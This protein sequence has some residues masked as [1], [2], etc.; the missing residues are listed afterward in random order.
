MWRITL[1]GLFAHKLRYGLTALSVVLAVGFMA[2]TLVFTDTI[3]RTFDGLFTDVYHSTSAVIRAKQPFTPQGNFTNQ[4]DKIDASLV[5]TVRAVPGV[6]EVRVGVE[7]YAQLV[8]SNH[9]AIGNPAAGAPT[10]GEAWNDVTLMNPYRFLPGGRPPR[11]ASEVAIDKHSADVGH[12][13]VG[14]RVLV[15][16]KQAP[17]VYTVTGIFRWETADSPLGASITLFDAVT[18]ARVL[19]SPGKVDEIDVA[20]QSGVTQQQMVDRLRA[21]VADP[22]LEVITGK[23][24]TQEGQSAIHKALSF[25]NLFLLIFA[26]IALFVGSFQ[27]FNTFSI[28]VAQRMREL[29]LV[30]AVGAGRAQVTRSI[31]GESLV[32]GVVA[33]VAG[34][35]AGVG[36]AIGLR[37]ILNAVG[38]VIPAAG[39][40]VRPRTIIVCLIVG[41]LITV[42]AAQSPARRAGRV[43]PIAVLREVATSEETRRLRR[44]VSGGAVTAA[45]L[46]LLLI[47]LFGQGVNRVALVG[48]GA[49]IVFLGLAVLGPIVSRPLSGLIG[50]ALTWRGPSGELARSNA[51]RNPKRTSATSAALMVGVALVAL[52]SVL[53]ASLK[54]S[55]GAAVDSTVRADFIVSGGG[56]PGGEA[57]FS[58]TLVQRLSRLPQVA[59]ATGVRAGS[60][61]V[62]GSNIVALAVD[63]RHVDDLFDVG[64]T[65]GSIS[66][67][68]TNGI[69]VS[70]A[71]AD[72]K[73]LALGQPLQ[74]VFPTTGAK[75]FT[76]Q[77]IYTARDVVG[78][79]VLPLAAAEQNY[80]Q[81]LDFQ[82]YV[83]LAPGVAASAAAVAIDTVLADYPTAKLLDRTQYKQQQQAQINQV[84][85]LVY[86]LLGLALTIALVGIANT[87]ALSIHERT[88]E[89]GLL[90]A[91]GMTRAQ[92]RSSVRLESLIIALLGT[93]E[94]LVVG[95]LFGGAVVAAL[96]S[97]G[98]S[99]LSIPMTQLAV[100]AVLAGVAGVLAAVLPSRRAARLDVLR[101]IT[102]D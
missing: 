4:R 90:R 51:M 74:V 101:A 73:H 53:A 18:A 62:G 78:D 31:L 102:T 38:L 13:A 71:A 97:H 63:P 75:T 15:L 84:L 91:I 52:M 5:S 35:M 9:K 95:T 6:A 10:L 77:A 60:V 36:L 44:A 41:T 65:A 30:R 42:L 76:V 50:S 19:G 29:A 94:G 79:Y 68:T 48:G 92:L 24:I 81:K 83:K 64:V 100:V 58:P 26:L 69:A 72:S 55:V 98:V 66:T 49:S 43:A 25:F 45:G 7:G 14:S 56:L 33:S 8:G 96:K 87:L 67:M 57:G 88:H 37:A 80:S 16:T 2:G 59:A 3:S 99:R 39:L 22:K 21:A 82:V 86:G 47:G 28:V 70:R 12:L 11:D 89:L 20:A 1:V 85:N 27:I 54:S 23:Q 17:T 46:T 32:I 40:L 93:A 61:R 34:I